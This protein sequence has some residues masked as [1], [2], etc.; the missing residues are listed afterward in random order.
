[1]RSLDKLLAVLTMWP[2]RRTPSFSREHPVDIPAP[3]EPEKIQGRNVMAFRN[4]D[5]LCL[6]VQTG[7]GL[8]CNDPRLD[9]TVLPSGEAMEKIGGAVVAALGLSTIMA[10]P[11]FQILFKSG[12]VQR[13]T[14]DW[15][16]SVMARFRYK[17]KR[18]L[19]RT[20]LK[21][22]IRSLDGTLTFAP[23][24]HDRLDGWSGMKDVE[25]VII[26]VANANEEVGR[27]L[28]AAFDLCMNDLV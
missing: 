25:K 16:R 13:H 28:F 19:W 14:A 22:S 18:A 7:R 21:C 12:D 17:T 11:D 15:E 27:A 2:W 1:M 8:L 9:G 20:M 24:R 3:N 6:F 5:F 10:A 23:T 26:P 4:E